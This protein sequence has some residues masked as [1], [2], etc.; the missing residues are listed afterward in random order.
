MITVTMDKG[1][2]TGTWGLICIDGS[3]NCDTLDL[4]TKVFGT[5]MTA[6]STLSLGSRN[7]AE[8]NLV[9]N[10]FNIDDLAIWNGHILTL[11]QID[12]LFNGGAGKPVIGDSLVT[13]NVTT[14][15]DFNVT[16]TDTVT[17]T[18]SVSTDLQSPQP[19]P[20]P[21]A[22]GE[23][24]LQ[25][26]MFNNFELYDVAGDFSPS[27]NGEGGIFQ[28]LNL[29]DQQITKIRIKVKFSDNPLP[30][31]QGVIISNLTD[32]GS[33][34]SPASN[35]GD[36]SS[37]VIEATS[38]IFNM[39]DVGVLGADIIQLNF[40]GAP[41]LTKEVAVGIFVVGIDTPTDEFEVYTNDESLF[42]FEQDGICMLLANLS[43]SAD[44]SLCQNFN[45]TS[46]DFGIK[47]FGND[48]L[49]AETIFF[50]NLNEQQR[51][52][53]SGQ[54]GGNGLSENFTFILIFVIC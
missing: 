19:A 5:P 45:P 1:N 44:L 14:I 46:N 36:F 38:D 11:A 52:T 7:D 20:N 15:T 29:T 34:V 4:G 24:V 54:S 25:G 31:V 33:F 12:E 10:K 42:P 27:V 28:T 30:T 53:L 48:L 6:N 50:N 41:F 39:T 13:T 18:D 9:E 22:G 8:G 51:T 40:T 23:I 26:H 32:D 35:L 49:T 16:I 47:V 17:V 43:A 37:M 2:T 21:I 3:S